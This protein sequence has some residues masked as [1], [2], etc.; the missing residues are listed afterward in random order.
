V[1]VCVCF[2]GGRGEGRADRRVGGT[3]AKRTAVVAGMSAYGLQPH[4]TPCLSSYY[5]RHKYD[6]GLVPS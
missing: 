4:P 5:I 2:G 3:V 1:C 6:Q